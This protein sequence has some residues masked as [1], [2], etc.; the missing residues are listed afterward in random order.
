MYPAVTVLKALQSKA[1]PVLW[2]GAEGG[3]EADLVQRASIPFA[4]I[5]AAGVHLSGR[6]LL[7]LPANLLK[8]ARGIFA[9]RKILKKFKPDALFFTG[10]YVAAPVAVAGARVPTVVFV[11]DIEPGLALKFLVR[12]AD[13]VAA[14][15][16]ETRAYLPKNTR[17]VVTGYPVRPELTAWN[18]DRAFE[19]FNLDKNLPVLLVSGGS[20][21]ARPINNAV[22]KNIAALTAGAQVIHITGQLGWPDVEA[23]RKTLPAAQADRYRAYPYL[24]E[25]TGAAFTIANLVV[26]RAGA[27]ALGEYPVFGLPAVLVPYPYAW[28]YQKVNAQYL[29]DRNAAVLLRD[30]DVEE[31]MAGIVTGLLNDPKKL[32]A[33]S[34]SMR[35]LAKPFAAADIGRLIEEVSRG[36]YS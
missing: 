7:R 17:M 1:D 16:P 22:M 36:G 19:F 8:L 24:H 4:A 15:T 11:P 23:F 5:P 20:R 34:A 32:A 10:G 31:Q 6:D 29:V 13:C 2:V 12:Y 26:S 14:V 21:G 35:A 18:R 3:M 27:S 25:E 30:E 9:A 28:R 33:M